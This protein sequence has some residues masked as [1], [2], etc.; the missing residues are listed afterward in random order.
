MHVRLLTHLMYFSICELVPDGT[1]GFDN[2]QVSKFSNQMT[3]SFSVR[4]AS[5]GRSIKIIKKMEGFTSS[6]VKNAIIT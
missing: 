3:N 2:F 6:L 1:S 4:T 5:I